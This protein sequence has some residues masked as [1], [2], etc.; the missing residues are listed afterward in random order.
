M[1]TA[2]RS[3]GTVVIGLG[4]PLMADDGVGL[5]ALDRLRG[6]EFDP[7]VTLIDGGTWGLNL[8]PVI[9]DADEVLLLDAINV[10][11]EPGTLTVLEMHQLPKYLSTKV[12]PHQV[13]L[14][15]VLALA[16]L[17]GR[18]PSRTAAIGIQPAIVEMRSGLSPA[19]QQGVD[20]LAR[21]A[22]QRLREWGHAA[23]TMAGH[24]FRA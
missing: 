17:R 21:A 15:D 19:V 18:L 6:V 13:D 14:H 8:L 12:S 20:A 2:E 5:A 23:R 4:N 11:A 7:P 1:W 22:V 10:A 3:G 24:A 16:E 9:E